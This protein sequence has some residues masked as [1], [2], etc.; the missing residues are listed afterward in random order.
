V[1]VATPSAAVTPIWPA[2]TL[3]SQF[4]S[5]RIACCNWRSFDIKCSNNHFAQTMFFFG[6]QNKKTFAPLSR[7]SGND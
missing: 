4:N 3:G 6:K 2:T 7:L 5:A 1:S